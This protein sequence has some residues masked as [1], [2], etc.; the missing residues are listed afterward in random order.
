MD[1]ERWAVHNFT[2]GRVNLYILAAD[3]VTPIR[4]DDVEVWGRWYQT[5]ERHVA[6]DMDENDP[7]GQKIRVSTVF[8]G[9]DHSW[10]SGPPVLWETMVFGGL[11]DGEQIR[12]TSHADAFEG[13]QRMCRDVAD[14]LKLTP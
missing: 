12:Y 3:G 14:S 8:L 5:A 4:V 1:F 11:L 13:H 7:T 6:H 2:E 10:G 9:M